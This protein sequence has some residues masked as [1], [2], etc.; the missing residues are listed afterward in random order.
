MPARLA[1]GLGLGSAPGQRLPVV[2]RPVP[3]FLGL[4]CWVPRAAAQEGATTSAKER[5]GMCPDCGYRQV[6]PEVTYASGLTSA[7]AGDYLQ[8]GRGVWRRRDTLMLH[9]LSL[10][11][12]GCDFSHGIRHGC[13][14][15]SAGARP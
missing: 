5:D 15:R 14:S 4:G 13:C 9:C 1:V 12:A 10:T 2:M 3:G 7:C 8:M 11:G 6:Y